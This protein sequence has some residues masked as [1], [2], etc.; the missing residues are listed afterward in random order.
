[1]YHVFLS[2]SVL[3]HGSPLFYVGW[4]VVWKA[5]DVATAKTEQALTLK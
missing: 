2:R 4:L 3:A 1:M 5:T